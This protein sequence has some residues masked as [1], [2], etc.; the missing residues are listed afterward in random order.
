MKTLEATRLPEVN[1]RAKPEYTVYRKTIDKKNFIQ[2]RDNY[3]KFVHD[4]FETIAECVVEY[5]GGVCI[6]DFMYVFLFQIPVKKDYLIAGKPIYNFHSDHKVYTVSIQFP[7]RYRHWAIKK[8]TFPREQKVKLKD[9]IKAGNKYKA[10]FNTLR[11][12]KFI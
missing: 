5:S 4:Y 9:S 3:F 2:G 10:Y 11:N 6:K 7:T 8:R 1:L 12:G